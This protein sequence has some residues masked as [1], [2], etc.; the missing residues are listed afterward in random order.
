VL[1]IPPARV[2]RYRKAGYA[3]FAGKR[4]A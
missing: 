3:G 2:W 4:K 1:N